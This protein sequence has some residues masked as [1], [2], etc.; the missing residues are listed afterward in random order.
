MSGGGGVRPAG[1]HAHVTLMWT[2]DIFFR[3]R[4]KN[5]GID[6]TLHAESNFDVSF[7]RACLGMNQPEITLMSRSVTR[8]S[9]S[10]HAHVTLKSRSSHAH[11]TPM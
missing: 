5:T 4:A 8:M 6:V 1:R 7:A 9:R 2:I 3:V 10:C 11:D